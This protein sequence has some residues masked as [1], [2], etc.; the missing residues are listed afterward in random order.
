MQKIR[1]IIET[2]NNEDDEVI[3]P[4]LRELVENTLDTFDLA[5]EKDT[6]EMRDLKNHL[7]RTNGD[8]RM[9]IIDFGLSWQKLKKS[10]QFFE[11]CW[12]KNEKCWQEIGKC[13]QKILIAW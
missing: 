3:D 10:G 11:K 2:L 5:L 1:D 9:E 13:W 12:Q 4:S 7:A 8:L 6:E